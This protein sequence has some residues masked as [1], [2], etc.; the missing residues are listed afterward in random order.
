M[1]QLF[2]FVY[3][4]IKLVLCY[5]MYVS[6]LIANHNLKKWCKSLSVIYKND[7]CAHTQIISQQLPCAVGR[8]NRVPCIMILVDLI[9]FMAMLIHTCLLRRFLKQLRTIHVQF[10]H[11]KSV[12]L[13]SPLQTNS[14]L[15][16]HRLNKCLNYFLF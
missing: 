12:I 5:R 9:C 8:E 7:L 15:I 10:D 13:G 1:F 4:F 3:F 14:N 11:G 2:S 6:C 16:A